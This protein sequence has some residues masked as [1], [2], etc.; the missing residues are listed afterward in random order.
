MVKKICLT[1]ARGPF[2]VIKWN[3]RQEYPRSSL[4]LLPPTPLP[5][6]SPTFPALLPSS[7]STLM[8]LPVFFFSPSFPLRLLCTPLPVSPPTTSSPSRNCNGATLPLLG[9][10]SSSRRGGEKQPTRTGRERHDGAEEEQQTRRKIM[11]ESGDR[12][13]R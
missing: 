4:L 10:P 13:C 11:I 12:G 3:T 8:S 7:F 6:R 2:A 5:P 9:R 1:A